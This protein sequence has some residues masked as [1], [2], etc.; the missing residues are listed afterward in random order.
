MSDQGTSIIPPG[1]YPDPENPAQG[2]FWNGAAWTD[3]RHVP[4]QPLPVTPPLKAPAGTDWNTPWIWLIIGL[5]LLPLLL[6][7]LVPWGSLFDF[8]PFAST[9][10]EGMGGM[11]SVFLSPFYWLSIV[12]SYG[13]YGL[14]VWFAYRDMKDLAARGVPKPFHWAFAFIGG[15]VYTIGRSVVV[16][17]RTGRGH[18]P[19]WAEIAVVV[20]S[21]VVV[22]IVEVIIFSA[23]GDLIT[24]FPPSR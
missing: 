3:V 18:A 17:R 13:V 15:L 12:S 1:W 4:G 23:M 7:L 11:V 2:R 21:I 10:A 5:P 20:V 16:K 14:S 6:L 8:D 9:P 24:T 22:V 19:L